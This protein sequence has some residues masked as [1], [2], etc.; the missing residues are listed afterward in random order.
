VKRA[1]HRGGGLS[2]AMKARQRL[3]GAAGPRALQ[4]RCRRDDSWCRL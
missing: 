1:V 3:W 4:W 2:A